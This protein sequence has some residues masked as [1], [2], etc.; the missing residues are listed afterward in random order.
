MSH[1]TAKLMCQSLSLSLSLSVCTCAW[2]SV[3]VKNEL[4]VHLKQSSKT[5]CSSHQRCYFP[6]VQRCGNNSR[7]LATHCCF[8]MLRS[9]P[10]ACIDE[11]EY[12]SV[13]IY[14][15]RLVSATNVY[16][17]CTVLNAPSKLFIGTSFLCTQYQI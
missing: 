5:C 17:C 9:R 12:G 7:A 8:I 16:V 1:N 2:A 10:S 14:C 11:S 3:C 15:V 4:C 6:H 13:R